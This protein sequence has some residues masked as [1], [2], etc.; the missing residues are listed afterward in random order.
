MTNPKIFIFDG[1]SGQ[2][3]LRD[4]NAE[5][6]AQ[7]KIDVAEFEANKAAELAKLNAKKEAAE[8]LIA[9]GIDPKALG[10]DIESGNG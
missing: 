2:E 8:K 3:L 5:E 7:N 9:L 10:L 4:F 1:E 6:L